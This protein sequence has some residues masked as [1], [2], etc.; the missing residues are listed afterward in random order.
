MP[1][2]LLLRAPAPDGPD[3]YETAFTDSGYSIYSI[4]VLE[5]VLTNL[6]D[7]ERVIRAGPF[8]QSFGGVI[9]TSARAC[10]AWKAVIGAI[11]HSDNKTS[12]D[13]S[14]MP[15]YVVGKATSAAFADL[16]QS[17]APS[18]LVPRDVRGEESGNA[19]Q[20]AQFIIEDVEQRP[21]KL[22][23]LT[24]DK[25]R[26][27]LSRILSSA[28]IE[29]TPLKVYETQGSSSF[30]AELECFIIGISEDISGWWIVFFAPS[31]A[32]FVTPVL[33]RHFILPSTS[34]A[35]SQSPSVRLQA[36]LAAIGP[37]TSSHLRDS[38]GL[39]V[40]V[41]ASKP[42]AEDLVSAIFEYDTAHAA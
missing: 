30:A 9:V 17:G 14:D 42:T 1:N 5:T 7:L 41:T 25:N 40:H 38:L 36:R 12:A 8:M 23:Y 22:L 32:N 28:N 29:P 2:V 27:T 11:A 16:A 39:E 33:R 24:G 34:E 3:K 18:N 31:A 21:A 37:T 4:P 6:S 26:D 35:W 10:E 15:F 19:E 13:W 20:L